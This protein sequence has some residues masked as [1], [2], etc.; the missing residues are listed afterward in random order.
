VVSEL[1]DFGV[2][3]DVIDPSANHHEVKEEYGLELAKEPS[4]K[5]DA[6]ILAVS[7]REYTNLDEN[8]FTSLLNKEGI[9]VDVKGILRGKIKNHIY[10]S[11]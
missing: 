7:H 8:Y 11:L 9:V 4:G 3:V 5:Y 6:V 10:W 1:N 2:V